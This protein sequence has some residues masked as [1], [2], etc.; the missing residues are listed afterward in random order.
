MQELC[1]LLPTAVFGALGVP[2]VVDVSK[3]R[4]SSSDRSRR[5]TEARAFRAT[6]SSSAQPTAIGSYR[7]SRRTARRTNLPKARPPQ[8]RTCRQTV[9]SCSARFARQC[10][11]ARRG[12]TD[13]THSAGQQ[14]SRYASRDLN[15]KILRYSLFL[16]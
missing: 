13:V 16:L 14:E 11:R 1:Y 6:A 9:N 8:C 15:L 4:W 2:E 7:K 5:T 12:I 10:G 3:I